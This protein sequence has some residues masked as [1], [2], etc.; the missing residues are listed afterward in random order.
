MEE[1]SSNILI[2]QELQT[3]I[4]KQEF[5]V[6]SFYRFLTI[7]EDRVSDF[8]N[9]FLEEG[10]KLSLGGLMILASEGFNGTVSGEAQSITLFRQ[11]LLDTFKLPDLW[12][13]KSRSEFV[14]Y[15][16]LSIRVRKEIVTSAMREDVRVRQGR[17]LTPEEWNRVLES[18]E[19]YF[20]IDTRN[21]YET[22]VGKFKQALDLDVDTFAELPQAVQCSQ[23]PKDKKILT[24]CTGGIR[25][26]K[27]TL[28][29]E[30]L[31]FTN[32]YQLEGGIL[33]Y[34]AQF[35][36]KHFEGECFVFDGRVAVDQELN[37]SK[38]YKLCPACGQPGK[39]KIICAYCERESII[40]SS[41]MEKR[42]LDTC[43]KNC[44]YHRELGRK[45]KRILKVKTN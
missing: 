9:F 45:P 22:K 33:N 35:P 6:A 1:K 18:N 23:I 7:E 27:A 29:L 32:V 37:P 28:E 14:P 26:E 31:G 43:S 38:S 34:L 24:Y 4:R 8:K 12:F 41:C 16:R 36:H 13:K 25:C 11:L 21:W 39:E 20:V 2:T 42:G 15:R 5:E 3:P 30:K 19:E 10:R 40:C 17:Y 44:R